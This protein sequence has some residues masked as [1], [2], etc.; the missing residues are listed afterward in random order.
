M[1][2]IA[3]SLATGFL[4]AQ[5]WCCIH[6]S[7]ATVS[8]KVLRPSATTVTIEGITARSKPGVRIWMS[9]VHAEK[10][11][12]A[13]FSRCQQAQRRRGGDGFLVAADVGT[14]E[15]M[16]RTVADSFGYGV[17]DD[18]V[19][20]EQ[21]SLVESRIADA[22]PRVTKGLSKQYKSIRASGVPLPRYDLWLVERL[23]PALQAGLG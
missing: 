21:M 22:L 19:I 2:D 23:K 12:A 3:S 10:V 11:M 13:F 8:S 15:Q 4:E 1:V 16:I 9:R 17:S 20:A 18:H 5:G 14:T 6:V 7:P